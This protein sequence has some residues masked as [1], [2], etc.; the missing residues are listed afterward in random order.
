MSSLASSHGGALRPSAHVTYTEL[1][2]TA[3]TGFVELSD[4]GVSV[5][6]RTSEGSQFAPPSIE[7]FKMMATSRLAVVR[8]AALG[9]GLC[10]PKGAASAKLHS[11]PQAG[12]T[13]EDLLQAA[14]LKL[15]NHLLELWVFAKKIAADEGSWGNGIELILTVGNF[16]HSLDKQ[17]I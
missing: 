17:P 15:G 6:R 9:I 11:T 2:D 4:P 10:I 7:L 8:I 1:P 5:S 13:Q 3:I 12:H 14:M 16:S